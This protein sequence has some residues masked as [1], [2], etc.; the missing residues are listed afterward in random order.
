[1]YPARSSI[2][3]NCAKSSSSPSF[4]PEKVTQVTQRLGALFIDENLRNREKQAADT[5][6]FYETELDDTRRRLEEREHEL[7]E[8]RTKNAA[9]LPSQIAANLQVLKSTQDQAHALQDALSRDRERRSE[10]EQALI[11]AERQAEMPV[12]EP[13]DSQVAADAD[14][15]E[16]TPPGS[17]PATND[18]AAPG[19]PAP[20]VD[21]ANNP[22]MNFGAPGTPTSVRLR[23]ARRYLDNLLLRLR[24]VHPEVVRAQR[25]V[26]TLE[27]LAIEQSANAANRAPGTAGGQARAAAVNAAKRR[28]AALDKE[29]AT[30]TAELLRLGQSITEYQRRVDSGPAHEAKLIELTRDYDII[31]ETY[32]SLL[33]KKEESGIAANM[34]RQSASEQFQIVEPARVPSRPISPNRPNFVF[35]GIG[36][37]LAFGLGLTVL[38]ELRDQSFR[39]A[40]E[41]IDVL[42]LPVLAMVPAIPTRYARRIFMRRLAVGAGLLV[43][44]AIV[45]GGLFALRSWW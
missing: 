24:P 13:T 26:A 37:G 40:P 15:A 32:R 9:S 5:S 30:K 42:A 14:P 21:A 44:V 31:R 2:K 10:L 19:D 20:A 34:A 35:A 36:I 29:I 27:K 16:P 7:Q 18:P 4:G 41:V 43:F 39:S 17:T 3:R 33:A 11:E 45:S 25:I 6:D 1:V 28:L 38:L 8:Y 12:E 23:N 22:E